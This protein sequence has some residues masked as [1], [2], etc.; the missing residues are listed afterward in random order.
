MEISSRKIFTMRHSFIFL[1]VHHTSLYKNNCSTHVFNKKVVL[2]YF[3]KDL[4][5]GFCN[6]MSTLD[7]IFSIGKT[8]V[9]HLEQR[10]CAVWKVTRLC[11][12]ELKT[13]M[14]FRSQFKVEIIKIMI[15]FLWWTFPVYKPLFYCCERVCV[16]Y[17]ESWMFCT[18]SGLLTTYFDSYLDNFIMFFVSVFIRHINTW[19]IPLGFFW[20]TL[21]TSTF[22]C[23]NYYYIL[24]RLQ[25][26]AC[27][28]L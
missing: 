7:P 13:G 27:H 2:N 10:W 4:N 6:Y 9:L 24:H 15:L 28:I 18:I 1:C 23:C 11:W 22:G 12:W 14:Y 3:F 26:R 21:P 16:H 8:P 20:G 17:F 25:G 5:W 19:W